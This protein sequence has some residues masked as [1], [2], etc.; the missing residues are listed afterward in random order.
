MEVLIWIG[1]AISLL[2]LAGLIACI[3]MATRA[4]R[5]GLAD[6]ELRD[7]LK[8]VVALNMGALMVSAIGLMC[9]IAGIMLS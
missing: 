2:G 8:R 3:V 7:R 1:A 4:K 9:V 5:A 6:A